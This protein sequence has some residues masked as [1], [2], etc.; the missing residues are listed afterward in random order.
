MMRARQRQLLLLPAV[1]VMALALG[2][3]AH[4]HLPRFVLVQTGAGST[5]VHTYGTTVGDALRDGGIPLAAHDRVVPGADTRLGTGMRIK[6]RRAFPVRL[7]AD[8]HPRVYLTAAETVR[9]FIEETGVGLGSA[10]R[11]FPAADEV[12]WA[13]ATVRIVRVTTRIVTVREPVPFGRLSRADPVMPRGL[14]RVV[15]TG[16]PGLRERRIAVT[17]A[18]GFVIKREEVGSAITRPAQ[19]RITHVGTRRVIA[20]RGQ[21]S[22]REVL[23]MEATAYAPWH[24]KGV[25]DITATGMKAGFGVVAVDPRFIPLGSVLFVEGYGQ[26]IAGD[27]GGAIKGFRIDLGFNTAREAYQFGRRP[28]RVYILS[29]PG[30]PQ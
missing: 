21:F 24:G 16:R 5:K 10:D 28:V 19:D 7:F 9:D 17:S 30:G 15:Q 8:G 2:A 12:I 11:V 20:S 14:T 18:D 22:G 25:N 23:H 13:G 6:I 4:A 26:A 3:A 29:T 1:A 27:T